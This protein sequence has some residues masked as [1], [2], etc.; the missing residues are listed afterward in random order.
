ML[1]TTVAVVILV[2]LSTISPTSGSIF[3]VDTFRVH[4]F[5]ELSDNKNLYV[6]CHCTD[7]YRPEARIPVGTD[8]NWSFKQHVF[9]ITHW[10]CLVAP[11]NNRYLWF[12]AYDD[13]IGT[14]NNN[15]YWV[16]KEDGVYARNP[17]PVPKKDTFL[18]GWDNWSA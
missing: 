17:N 2:I 12:T 11:D 15:V 13:A 5:N 16:A 18:H 9:S 10:R 3:H 8:Y 7:G 14:F 1:V 6:H 4:I